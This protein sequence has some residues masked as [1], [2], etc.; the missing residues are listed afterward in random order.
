MRNLLSAEF[1]RLWK[2]K[3]FWLTLC[4]VLVISAGSMFSA[5]RNAAGMAAAGYTIEFDDY[6]FNLAPLVGLFCAVFTSLFIGTEYGDGTMRNKIIVG[7]TRT[8][9]YLANFVV[10]F[11]AGVCFVAVWLLGGLVGVPVMGVLQMGVG[12]VLLYIAIFIF[13]TAS[14]IGIFTLLCMLSSNKAITAVL[15]LLLAL[16]LLLA[17][18]I[19]YNALSEPELNGGM[20]VTSEGMFMQE[21]TPNPRYVTGTKRLVYE[22]VI[23]ALPTGQGIL[24]ANLAIGRPVTSL[25]SSAVIALVTTAAGVWFFKKKDIK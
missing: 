19:V 10:C 3:V 22:F 15:A 23:N 20:V 5:M 24:A 8:Q 18:S 1:H 11:V 16:G 6:Y 9:I 21:P 4:A 25:A 2:N 14:L 13:F 17:A 12:G 7:R